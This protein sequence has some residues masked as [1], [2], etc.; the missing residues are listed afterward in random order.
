MSSLPN[1]FGIIKHPQ[2]VLNEQ[3]AS[4]N[5]LSLGTNVGCVARDLC[6]RELIALQVMISGDGSSWGSRVGCD[7]S[8]DITRSVEEGKSQLHCKGPVSRRVAS[9]PSDDIW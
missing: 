8:D 7:A 9:V 3:N 2:S 5:G 4:C 1:V 6:S